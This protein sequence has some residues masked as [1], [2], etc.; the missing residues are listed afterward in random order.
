[1]TVMV[2]DP[3]AHLLFGVGE[4][5]LFEHRPG[6]LVYRHQ[7]LDGSVGHLWMGVEE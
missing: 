4:G 3:R 5:E 2:V 1:M 6:L 7:N